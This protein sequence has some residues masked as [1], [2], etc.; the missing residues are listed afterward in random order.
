MNIYVPYTSINEATTFALQGYN[1]IY[2]KMEKQESYLEFLKQRWKEGES[3][4]NVEHDV[5]PWIGA[6]DELIDCKF[7]WCA[8]GYKIKESIE[9][10]PY[11]GCVKF[12]SQLIHLLPEIWNDREKISKDWN[13]LDMF[14]EKY[15]RDHGIKVHQHFPA[16]HNV[17]PI[18]AI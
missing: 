3:F 1:P 13:T 18:K 5:V 14:M 6:I 10:T 8:Y 11:F 17:K 4:I 16:V 7:T 9:F 15:A 12:T 2:V